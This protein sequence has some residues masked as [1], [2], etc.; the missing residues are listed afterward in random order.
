MPSGKVFGIRLMLEVVSSK[1]RVSLY[2][3]VVSTR[4]KS[5]LAG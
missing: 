5:I 1:S 3:F 4:R 2:F